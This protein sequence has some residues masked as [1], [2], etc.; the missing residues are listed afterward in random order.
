MRKSFVTAGLAISLLTGS[1]AAQAATP[2]HGA[3]AP[4]AMTGAGGVWNDH[5]RRWDDRDDRPVYRGSDYR[6]GNYYGGNGY[7]GQQAYARGD[8]RRDDDGRRYCRRNDGST[9]LVVG[10]VVGGVLGHEVAGRGGDR[11]LGA[12]LG[13]AGGAL[14]GRAIDRDGARCR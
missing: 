12:I 9:G 14:L 2:P 8:Q 4:A 1:F 13:I 10:G 7:Y 5:G 3:S 6:G 11:T